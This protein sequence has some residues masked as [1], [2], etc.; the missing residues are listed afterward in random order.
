MFGAIDQSIINGNNQQNSFG[1]P[2]AH[3]SSAMQPSILQQDI[4]DLSS[5]LKSYF[6]GPSAIRDLFG[7]RQ[8]QSSSGSSHGFLESLF[9]TAA[10]TQPHQARPAC[11][12]I[13]DENT[14]QSVKRQPKRVRSPYLTQSGVIGFM[15][16]V[17]P[18]HLT[19]SQQREYV[20]KYRI[21]APNSALSKRFRNLS[22]IP[23]DKQEMEFYRIVQ[24][25]IA[26]ADGV[27]MF[28]WGVNKEASDGYGGDQQ[29]VKAT[30]QTRRAN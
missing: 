5:I 10:A 28:V 4:E 21:L 14:P 15:P 23:L 22:K 3:T 29:M 12:T 20:T 7:G 17:A 11:N 13:G 1:N 30:S 24:R 8:E 6:N 26:A 18:Y 27:P 16:L 2:P 9:P 19:E 25:E